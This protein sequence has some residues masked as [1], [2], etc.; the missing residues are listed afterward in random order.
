MPFNAVVSMD[1]RKEYIPAIHM[2]R[3]KPNPPISSDTKS[4]SSGYL[5]GGQITVKFIQPAD[6]WV[7]NG[8]VYVPF[9]CG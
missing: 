1:A 5:G 3:I 2:L 8:W 9:W 4:Q 6:G 7:P